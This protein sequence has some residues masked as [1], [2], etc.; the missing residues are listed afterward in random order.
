M[1]ASIS[2]ILKAMGIILRWKE[3]HFM[4]EIDIKEIPYKDF[5]VSWRV[6]FSGLGVQMMPRRPAG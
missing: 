6:I 3:F 1:K 5:L 4:I 2:S